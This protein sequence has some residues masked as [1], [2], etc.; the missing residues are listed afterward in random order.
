MKKSDVSGKTS[1]F[2]QI[3]SDVF[4]KTSEGKCQNNGVFLAKTTII[5]RLSKEIAPLQ[6]VEKGIFSHAPSQTSNSALKLP[7][8]TVG[9]P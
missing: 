5:G 1:E 2:F 7:L 8:Y 9:F 4:R 6:C 3:I